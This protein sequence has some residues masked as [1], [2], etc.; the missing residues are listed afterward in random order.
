MLIEVEAGNAKTE[1]RGK[2]KYIINI[3]NNIINEEA[4]GGKSRI[5]GG[6]ILIVDL[7]SKTGQG[8]QTSKY[9]T[10][11]KGRQK[12]EARVEGVGRT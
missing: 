1:A 8:K 6:A 7:Y 5:E 12:G 2:K 11:W 10:R 3:H 4:L 9:I